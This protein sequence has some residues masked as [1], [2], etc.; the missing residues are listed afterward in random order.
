[1][2]DKAAVARD[3][4]EQHVHFVSSMF[5]SISPEAARGREITVRE[6]LDDAVARVDGSFADLPQVEIDV[7]NTFGQAYASIGNFA[8]AREQFET[9]IK[10]AGDPAAYVEPDTLAM[11]ANY[12]KLLN[13]SGD[14]AGAH[15]ALQLACDR[16]AS[17]VGER[18]L[19]TLDARLKLASFL[20]DL[21]QLSEA[22]ALHRRSIQ[23]LEGNDTPEAVQLRLA[24]L[25]T[26]AVVK[27][28][29][30][31][32]SEAHLLYDN[33]REVASITLD[34]THPDFIAMKMGFASL[35]RDEGKFGEALAL[36]EPA[37]QSAQAVFGPDH[38]NTLIM[39]HHVG[40]LMSANGRGD[41]ARALLD[42]ALARCRRVFGNDHATTLYTW[43]D[44]FQI[45]TLARKY[46]PTEEDMASLRELVALMRRNLGET[47]RDTLMI[48]GELAR[49][50]G[51]QGNLRMAIDEYRDVLE[52]L[53]S[54]YG[55]EHH[56]TLSVEL[57]LG[58]NLISVGDHASAEPLLAHAYDVNRRRSRTVNDWSSPGLYGVCLAGLGKHELA[59]GPLL[60]AEAAMQRYR[61]LDVVMMRK[62]AAALA[63]CYRG[64]HQ[65]DK[66][67]HYDEVV[68]QMNEQLAASTQPAATMDSR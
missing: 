17:E 57:R 31:N 60:E 22:E 2:R 6:V 53:R 1:E 34:E 39:A 13:D 44:W 38:P 16:L 27:H 19:R 20:Y 4:A 51:V 49:L 29:Q 9:A 5:R 63:G 40:L 48:R 67:Q 61:K 23:L 58:Q 52:K 26:L 21:D 14:R 32:F 41:E 42:D 25:T 43:H 36:V 12:G 66:A 33:A 50:I 65:Q 7:R 55:D 11:Y 18:D 15:R 10:K 59:L 62:V 54:T 24:N 56:Y 30:G 46:V 64:L 8:R 68:R 45:R 3:L 37:F 47:H 35:L 28:Q